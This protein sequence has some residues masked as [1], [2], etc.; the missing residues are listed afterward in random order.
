MSRRG[1]FLDRT[2]ETR[3][4]ARRAAAQLRALR[5]LLHRA[6]RA[7]GTRARLARAGLKPEALRTLDDLAAVPILRKSDLP[8]LQE[9]APPFAGLLG[10]PLDRLARIYISPGPTLDPEGDVPDY[11]R[12]ARALAAA[13]F[14]KGDLVL[15]RQAHLA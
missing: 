3:L 8:T 5:A 7:S 12:F 6:V 14:R 15:S 10:L 4:P 11:W 2:E 13:G 9:Q 1:R